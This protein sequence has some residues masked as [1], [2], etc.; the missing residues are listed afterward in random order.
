MHHVGHLP[1]I[2]GSSSSSSVV[3]KPAAEAAKPL[4]YNIHVY[5]IAIDTNLT[6]LEFD[7][8]TPW[9]IKSTLNLVITCT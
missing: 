6:Y 2:S 1:R 9:F 8:K 4:I 3:I 5:T 7:L